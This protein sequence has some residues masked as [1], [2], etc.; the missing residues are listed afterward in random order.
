MTELQFTFDRAKAIETILYLAKR[1]EDPTLHSIGKLLYFSDKTSLE[2]Y[3]RFICGDDYYAMKWGPVPTHTYDLMKEAANQDNLPF[4]LH[5][6]VVEP[7]RDA[8]TDILSESDIECLD[9][10]IRLYGDVPMWKR[11][12]DSA[13]RA[14]KQAWERRGASGSVRM[15]IE[16]IAS[17]LD[18][19]DELIA[20]LA[21]R[22]AE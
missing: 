19:G 14:Y 12:E 22:G 16:D 15:S 17:L 20:F 3:G 18:D 4:E 6:Y 5:G 10:S 21:H 1:I 13:D 9:A 11:H 7:S 2:K 8:D